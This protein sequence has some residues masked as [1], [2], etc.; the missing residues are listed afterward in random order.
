VCVNS[1]SDEY[2][3]ESA[4]KVSKLKPHCGLSVGINFNNNLTRHLEKN[5]NK[6]FSKESTSS[7]LEKHDV[8]SFFISF[9]Y[10]YFFFWFFVKPVSKCLL[11]TINKFLDIGVSLDA[12]YDE[13]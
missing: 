2:E 4:F 7:I 10:F 1:W 5:G 12:P 11:D 8:T 3:I 9:G 6:I 13:I